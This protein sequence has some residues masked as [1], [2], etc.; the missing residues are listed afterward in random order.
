MKRALILL[1][2]LL[3]AGCASPPHRD[4]PKSALAER[5]DIGAPFLGQND[6][7]ATAEDLP[8]HW[9]SLYGDARLD[10]YVEQA[11]AANTDL[12]AADANLRRASAIVRE[13]EAAMGPQTG[14]TGRVLGART[15]GP[16]SDLPGDFSYSLGIDVGYPLDFDQSLRLGVEATVAQ[17]EAAEAA[18]DQVRV[19]TA[20]AVTRNYARI[21]TA[22]MSLA[23]ARGVAAVRQSTLQVADRLAQSGRGTRFDVERAR[24][25]AFASEAQV[26]DILAE[27]QA[28][29]FTL[30]ALMGRP[31]ADYPQDALDCDAMPMLAAPIPVGDGARLIRR[32]PD[33]RKAE[34]TLAAA[35]SAIGIAQADLY[36]RI[37][38]GGSAGSAGRL[39]DLLNPASF[40][41]SLGPVVTWTLPNRKAAQARI[42]QAGAGAQAAL[43]GFDGSILLALQQTESA[44]SAYGRAQERMQSLVVSAEAAG[45]AAAD[46]ETLQKFGRTPF[47][48]VL[49]A[50]A[51]HA[52][53][54]ASLSKARTILIDRQIDLFLVLGGGWE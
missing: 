16:T 51:S 41:F 48:D 34:R 40:G 4:L 22:N 33:V 11:L 52:D 35:T 28:A 43:A 42:E 44:L 10:S 17:A 54:Q 13:A 20:A 38:L 1:S 53:A 30:T 31:P 21:C 9:W 23:A 12:R 14:F 26:P 47:L 50:Q 37:S 7:A 19:V 8:A 25:A 6:A 49:N 36:P 27:R 15:A 29:L 45:R 2:L 3:A 39:T 5:T 18:R 46:A 24:A 32:R